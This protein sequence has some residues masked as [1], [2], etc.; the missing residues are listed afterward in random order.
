MHPRS[1]VA[2]PF[3]QLCKGTGKGVSPTKS[4]PRAGSTRSA[5]KPG[6]ARRSRIFARRAASR[7][8]PEGIVTRI[9]SATAG[10]RPRRSESGPRRRCLAVSWVSQVAEASQFQR[11]QCCFLCSPEDL[12]LF[13][14]VLSLNSDSWRLRDAIS[15]SSVR[16]IW[17]TS[18]PSLRAQSFPPSL[19]PPFPEPPRFGLFSA[20]ARSVLLVSGTYWVQKCW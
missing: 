19:P 5:E 10:H 15:R 14:V 20:R 6:Q 12:P 3:V 17:A 2:A 7:G 11:P 4:V 16:W 1:W 13:E 9:A 8:G 18:S